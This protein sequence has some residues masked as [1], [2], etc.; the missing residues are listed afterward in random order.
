MKRLF[1]VILLAA[2]AVSAF[3]KV[4][5]WK[6]DISHSRVGFLATHMVISEVEGQFGEFEA[7]LTQGN[8]DF[9]GSSV[10]ATIKTASINTNSEMRDKH[11]RA[12]DFFNAEKYPA[13]RF[14]STAFEKTGDR[15]YTIKGDLTIRD[16]TKP[17]ELK[18]VMTGP[19]KD[20]YGKER[21]AFK[22]STVVKRFDYGVKW[23]KN[24]DNGGLVVGE[25][26][27]VDLVLQFVR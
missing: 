10:E 3:A 20:P 17:V 1:S 15:T 8:P 12:D 11:L 25:D 24:L 16:V 21:T 7:T 14:K 27:T 2:L 13:I 23:S 18:A 5:V 22:A 6:A 26:V 19:I 9:S 4:P